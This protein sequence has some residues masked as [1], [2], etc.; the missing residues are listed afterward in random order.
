MKKF[1]KLIPAVVMLLIA[2]MLMG[3]TTYAW[4]SMNKTVTASGMKVKATAEGSIVITSA[5]AFPANGTQTTDYNFNDASAQSI[6]ASTLDWT[7]ATTTGLKK[8]TN[9]ELINPETGTA[10]N[11]TASLQYTDVSTDTSKVYYKD[12][13]VFITGDGQEFTNQTITVSLTGSFATSTKLINKA[14]S[15]AFYGESIT[16]TAKG[17]TVSEANY[18]GKLNV[19]GVKN[20]DTNTA[21]TAE[22]SFTI[23]GVTI[24]QTGTSKAYSITMRVYFDGALLETAGATAYATYVAGTGTAVANH[25]YYLNN[26]GVGIATV[27]EG[28]DVTDY[29]VTNIGASASATTFARTTTAANVE[30]VTLIATFVASTPAS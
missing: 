4:F 3:T 26:T 30:D 22:T 21:T 11:S 19:A 8:V 9:A 13:S 14:I 29:F 1:K 10:L 6:Y 24:P 2:T 12:Y 27:E 17:A 5:S 7:N 28:A 20:N 18:K 15:V 16:G 25:Y 23:T